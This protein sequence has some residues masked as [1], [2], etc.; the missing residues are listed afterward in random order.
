[1]HTRASNSELVEPLP[2]PEST[3]N[4]RLRRRNR[5]VPF[6]QRNNPPQHPRVVYAP[7]LDI[8]YFRH[9][10][11]T[12]QNL[13][14]MD[15]ETLWAADRVVARLSVL[16][17]TISLRPQRNLLLKLE[18]C[19]LKLR[20][21]HLPANFVIL[22]MGEDSKV[23]LSSEDL[24]FTLLMRIDVIDEILEEDFDALRRRK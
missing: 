24:F 12:L 15:D 19:S 16:Q 23:P 2:E 21:F 9:F 3:L 18:I 8:N 14:S 6:E 4:R 7:I 17:F 1:M 10:L 22:E 13:N 11:I 20:K 5:I